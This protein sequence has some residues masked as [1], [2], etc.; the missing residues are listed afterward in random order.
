VEDDV[1]HKLEDRALENSP[2][3]VSLFIG[4]EYLGNRL[5]HRSRNW[6]VIVI[7]TGKPS[8]DHFGQMASDSLSG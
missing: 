4:C 5:N 1:V 6:S 7:Q 3:V 2:Q 8:T